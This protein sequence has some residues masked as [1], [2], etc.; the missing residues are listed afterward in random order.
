M[1]STRALEGKEELNPLYVLRKFVIEQ[2]I[3]EIIEEEHGDDVIFGDVLR[4]NKNTKIVYK[5]SSHGGEFIS[6]LS[7]V[8]LVKFPLRHQYVAE[9]IKRKMAKWMGFKEMSDLLD[10][11]SGATEDSVLGNIEHNEEG[12]QH[13]KRQRTSNLKGK[14]RSSGSGSSGQTGG[15]GQISMELPSRDRNEVLMVPGQDFSYVLKIYDTVH[16]M[17]QQDHALKEGG[18]KNSLQPITAGIVIG[19]HGKTQ[20]DSRLPI[21]IVPSTTSSL[22]SMFNTK[23]FLTDGQFVN[24]SN[25]A[26]SG[27]VVKPTKQ[28]ITRT[29]LGAGNNPNKKFDYLVIDNPT[30]LKPEDWER[31]VAVV[32]MGK[33]WQFKGWKW[34]TPVELFSHVLGLFMKYDNETVPPLVG[35]WNVKVLDISKNRRTLDASCSIKFWSMVDHHTHHNNPKFHRSNN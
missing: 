31:V 20:R 9:H 30:R 5:D 4:V 34:S 6:I 26:S 3:S 29:I 8:L 13:M 28:V 24:G 14:T 32:S 19:G 2:R 22:M 23:Q 18:R 15:N 1:A 17:K 33:D 25:V 35:K 11:L 16:A 10:F 27:N 7:A 12:R 21:I